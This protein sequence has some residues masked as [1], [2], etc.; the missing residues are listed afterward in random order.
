VSGE[1]LGYA[2]IGDPARCSSSCDGNV[3]S[4]RDKTT[5]NGSI[6]ADGSINIMWHELSET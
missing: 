4:F 1:T 2:M 3:A 5:P 6:D